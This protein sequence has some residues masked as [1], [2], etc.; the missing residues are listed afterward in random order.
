MSW[1]S[2][3]QSNAPGQFAIREEDGVDAL[4]ARGSSETIA[5]VFL[6]GIRALAGPL[7]IVLS[8]TA[9]P[10]REWSAPFLGR[11]KVL[12]A[13][14]R[15]RDR[16]GVSGLDLGVHS[17]QDGIELAL[18]RFGTLEGRSVPGGLEALG[19]ALEGRGF[20]RVERLPV[21]PDRNV[22]LSEWTLDA[23]ARLVW[24]VQHLG[25][26]QGHEAGEN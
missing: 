5:D 9:P 1:F 25:C 16:L 8:T 15:I 24:V 23:E 6:E 17:E 26:G 11:A 12:E 14:M 2:R 7:G 21:L 19:N 22:N 18:D 10:L 20:E 13:L 4:R 3:G